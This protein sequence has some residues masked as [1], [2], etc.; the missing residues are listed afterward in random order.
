MPWGETSPTGGRGLAQPPQPGQRGRS[1]SFPGP[2]TQGGGTFLGRASYSPARMAGRV[3]RLSVLA[4]S[5]YRYTAGE[6]SGQALTG[7]GSRTQFLEDPGGGAPSSLNLGMGPH[8]TL[9]QGVPVLCL[10]WMISVLR[11]AVLILYC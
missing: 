5:P 9:S 6:P 4:A 11:E 10:R 8:C 1:T 7:R 3:R 2:T